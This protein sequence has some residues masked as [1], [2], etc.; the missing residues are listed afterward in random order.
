MYLNVVDTY[1]RIW[2]N[3]EVKLT[4]RFWYSMELALINKDS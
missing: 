3:S 2:S 4:D 1:M